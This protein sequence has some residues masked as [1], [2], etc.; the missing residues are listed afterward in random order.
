MTSLNHVCMWS[1]HGWVRVTAEEAARKHPGG[2]VSANSGLFMCELCGQFVMLTDGY[3]RIRYFKHSAKEANKNCPER[4]FGFSYIPSYTAGEH[5]LPIKLIVCR[6]YFRLEL[7]L[8]YVPESILKKQATQS[9]TIKTAEEKQFVFSFERLNLDSITYL[10]IGKEPSQKYEVIAPNELSCYWPQKVK[11]IDRAGSVFDSRT[12]KML[13]VDADVQVNRQYYILTT[14]SYAYYRHYSSVKLNKVCDTRVGWLTWTVYEVEATALDQEAAKFF[15][16]LHCRLTDTP[17]RMQPVWPIHIET[18]Y[19]IK[20]DKSYMIM[21]L[22][23]GRS[24]TPKTFPRTSVLSVNCPSEGQVIKIDCIGRQ[25][26]ISAG[27]ANVLQ[28]TYLW[29]EELSNT[30]PELSIDVRDVKDNELDGGEQTHLPEAGTITIT[31]PFDGTAIICKKGSIIEKLK[32]ASGNR[33]RIDNIQYGLK[34]KILQGLDIIWEVSYVKMRNTHVGADDLLY[35]KLC[36]FHGTTI[37]VPHNIG[38]IASK[39]TGYP[40]T[41]DWIY[42]AVKNGLAQEVAIKYLKNYIVELLNQKEGELR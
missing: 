33:L 26:L 41:K 6:T 30:I 13:P 27:S 5:E 2:T 3:E 21:H 29:K 19:V 38:S 23:G 15:L 20:H 35:S 8:L 12:G 34:I 24:V 28:Y 39:L 40:K 17:L 1:E 18:P 37:C 7:G 9:V 11:G 10:S 32:I 22:T 42:A 4:T 31:A 25:Q 14:A 16:S 36:S